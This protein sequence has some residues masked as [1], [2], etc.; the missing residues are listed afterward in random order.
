[1]SI[2]DLGVLLIHSNTTD[3]S[4][5]FEDS[6]GQ[7]HTITGHGDVHH[8]TDAKKFGTTSIYFDDSGDYLT[9]PT[10]DD[11][12]F[13]TGDF[14]IDFW[15]RQ[16]VSFG[17]DGIFSLRQDSS[18]L[19][20]V[21]AFFGTLYVVVNGTS[22]STSFSW[23]TW[24][25]L[26]IVRNGNTVTVYLS[27]TSFG[28]KDVTGISFNDNDSG[29]WIG[30]YLSTSNEFA[31]YVDELR[32]LKGT[33]EWTS[34]F[35]PY[36]GPYEVA[37]DGTVQSPEILITTSHSSDIQIPVSSEEI[38]LSISQ[39]PGDVYVGTPV[40]S[41]EINLTSLISS[42]LQIIIVQP[43]VQI[44]I[45]AL[46]DIG[47]FVDSSEV[48]IVSDHSLGDVLIGTPIASPEL[49]IPVTLSSD[50]GLVI[51]APEVIINL[52][53]SIGE[54]FAGVRIQTPEIVL[55]VVFSSDVQHF[56][57]DFGIH[58]TGVLLIHSDTFD[59]DT[60]IVDSSGKGHTITRHG[61]T[62]PYHETDEKYFG[63]TSILFTN[64]YLL[65]PTSDDFDFGYGD[66]TVDFW[67]RANTTSSDDGLFTLRRS[68][69]SKIWV[70]IYNGE[71]RVKIDTGTLITT[72][73]SAGAWYHFAVVRYGNTVTVY[74]NGTSFGSQDVTGVTFDD[75][76]TGVAIGYY[77]IEAFNPYDGY[78]DEFRIVKG[79]ACWTSNFTPFDE[80]YHPWDGTVQS[81]EI[82]ITLL[83]SSD[84]QLNIASAEALMT[85]SHFVDIVESLIVASAE[86][87]VTLLPAPSDL[88]LGFSQPEIQ[89]NI[90]NDS[91]IQLNFSSPES[92]ITIAS[93]IDEVFTGI[94]LPSPEASIVL[95]ALSDI[96]LFIESAEAILTGSIVTNPS[97]L[98]WSPESTIGT[99]IT[100]AEPPVVTFT[101]EH[102]DVYYLFTLTGDADGTTDI[103]I[104]I[105]SFQGRLRSGDPSYLSVVIPGMER[106]AEITAR[107]NGDLVIEM[108][109][110]LE[111]VFIQREEIARVTLE[112]IRIDQGSTNQS[113]T[114]SGHKT[115]TYSG[116]A[117]TITQSPTYYNLTAGKVRY[118]FPTANMNL[119]P[120]DVVTVGTD[121]FTAG[122]ITYTIGVASQQMEVSEA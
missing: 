36:T 24:Y 20:H 85:L 29:L 44:A 114:L 32:I 115:E 35:T 111:G 43:E 25:H 4:T 79:F 28:S 119:N 96:G 84:T 58:Q 105:K 121:V 81:E 31:G 60:N 62:P 33:A 117:V 101:T 103:E 97:I 59:G 82:P 107:S 26:A 110:K 65:V 73:L 94:V 10:S 56:R 71:L 67:F 68:G 34:N 77:A 51:V 5:T 102:A 9:V 13:G 17:S 113:I 37:W 6:S 91:D 39:N 2:E 104:P 53:H 50:I 30:T 48:L 12:D 70:L 15:F 86:A 46:T 7:G 106:S 45:Q 116:K 8:E 27:G 74:L 108:A 16:N 3:G 80:P 55:P 83:N 40:V 75:N 118:R 89:L 93:S 41:D 63:A 99:V 23:D 69:E 22:I 52:S 100:T 54:V 98:I 38:A 76:D 42:D 18:N 122:L 66:F 90:D 49:S 1:M 95:S 72:T 14:T 109:Y 61:T 64:S 19:L 11:F 47:L 88:Q 112:D 57:A 92:Q 120:G 78:I 21:Y 87:I